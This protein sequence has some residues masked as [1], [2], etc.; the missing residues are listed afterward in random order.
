[1]ICLILL[2]SWCLK[3]LEGL[4]G[5]RV[6]T[7]VPGQ[8]TE[9]H[10]EPLIRKPSQENESVLN[11]QTVRK[12]K[13]QLKRK[14]EASTGGV[15]ERPRD[16]HVENMK[17]GN[18]GMQNQNIP[19]S[20]K[21][22]VQTNPVPFFFQPFNSINQI[23]TKFDQNDRLSPFPAVKPPVTRLGLRLPLVSP[24]HQ[25]SYL[26]QPFFHTNLYPTFGV[27]LH[28]LAS[29]RP[30]SGIFPPQRLK[31]FNSWYF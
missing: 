30:Y 11:K 22:K 14:S 6:T 24:G 26:V 2:E 7:F 5:S 21:R 31:H 25:S 18:I 29:I 16:P 4:E 3:C 23:F 28:P 20:I 1:M 17:V 27:P 8:S 15:I 12:K 9:T 13:T 10:T 19:H